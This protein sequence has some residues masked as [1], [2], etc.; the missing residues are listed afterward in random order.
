MVVDDT[1]PRS[2][3]RHRRLRLRL[4]VRGAVQGVGFRPYVYRLAHELGLAGWVS[5]DIRGV[6]IEVEGSAEAVAAFRRRLPAEVPP[7]AAIHRRRVLAGSRAAS[8]RRSHGF[9]IRASLADG[10]RTAVVLP[11]VATCPECLAELLDPA[12]RRHGYP[13]T[14]CTH[15]G[16][17]F[18]IVRALPYDRPNTTMAGFALCPDCRREYEDP[19]D[20]RFHAQPN[21][22]PVCGPRLALWDAERPPAGA[23]TRLTGAADALRRGEIVALK[24]LGGFQLLVDARNAEAV[25][26]LRA[27]KHRE[28]KPF[29]VM[30]RGPRDGSAALPGAGGRGGAARLAGGAD[31]PARRLPAGDGRARLA[32]RSRRATR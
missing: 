17:R 22:C 7:L 21:A 8:R 24:G 6:E 26:R 15:C 30:V 28:E 32:P 1:R 12:A 18:T 19:G 9:E 16:P 2:T 29:A 25:A 3:E 10:A 23:R 31:R 11:D 14:N 20:R 27:R 13:F 5:N 4:S